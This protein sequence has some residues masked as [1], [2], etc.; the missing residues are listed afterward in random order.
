MKASLKWFYMLHNFKTNIYGLCRR[1]Q[2]C[3]TMTSHNIFGV[4]HKEQGEGHSEVT[5]FLKTPIYIFAE[6][7]D[8]VVV[9][10]PKMHSFY[11]HSDTKKHYACHVTTQQYSSK[12]V[13]L[14][15]SANFVC[16]YQ[17]IC[18]L[19]HV[20]EFMLKWFY[21]ISS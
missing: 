13:L 8:F 11:V 9:L 5:T 16:T 3:L 10:E 7:W 18:N 17:H 12:N 4:P 1:F 20:N 19:T 6:N 14:G 2:V 21:G 15:M